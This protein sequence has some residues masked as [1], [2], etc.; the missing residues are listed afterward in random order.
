M[1]RVMACRCAVAVAAPLATLELRGLSCWLCEDSKALTAAKRE[2]LF[3]RLK[4]SNRIGYVIH[5]ISA[6][7]ISAK[8]L[9]RCGSSA[10]LRV[11][12][13]RRSDR[14]CDV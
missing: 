9:L 1:V 2:E 12:S 6:S 11:P 13:R 3:E 5:S 8:M 7:E 10:R 14:T 4:S